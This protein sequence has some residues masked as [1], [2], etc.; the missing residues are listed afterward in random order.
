MKIIGH[1]GAK[2]E[3]PENTIAG[4][5]YLQS[6]GINEMELDVRLSRDYELVVIHDH[7]VDRTSNQVGKVDQYSAAEL[8]ALDARE[9]HWQ[10]LYPLQDVGIPRLRNVLEAWPNLESIQIEVKPPKP[11]DYE[12]LS[13][14]LFTIC[15]KYQLPGII[16]SSD[17]NF[18]QFL[19]NKSCPYVRGYVA[20]ARNPDPITLAQDLQCQYLIAHWKI[21]DTTLVE[22]AHDQGLRVSSWTV[23]EEDIFNKLMALEIESIITDYPSKFLPLKN[24]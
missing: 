24:I 2:Q 17:I 18:L 7:T 12:I 10:T 3:A 20:D 9:A 22:R 13:N 4:F 21:C 5:K 14:G 19:K 16:T 1:R 23:N 6:L 8:E 15:E 11:F